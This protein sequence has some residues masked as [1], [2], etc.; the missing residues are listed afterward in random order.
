MTDVGSQ[1]F[2][3]G[4]SRRN[5]WTEAQIEEL[6]QLWSDDEIARLRELVRLRVPVRRIAVELGKTESPV[7]I[8]CRRLGLTL[9]KPKVWARRWSE[10]DNAQLT[11]LRA[12]GKTQRRSR[13]L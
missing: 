7:Q 3:D 1:L 6:K 4:T 2:S 11:H 13:S 9:P 8:M 5:V 10:E 12:E